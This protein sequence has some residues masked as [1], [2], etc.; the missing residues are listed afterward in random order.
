MQEVHACTFCVVPLSR[1]YTAWKGAHGSL[2]RC[3]FQ[4]PCQQASCT[5]WRPANVC[6][7]ACVK[8][9]LLFLATTRVASVVGA[10][11]DQACHL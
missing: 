3:P 10:Y 9:L 11:L 7:M 4:E 2:R 8:W 6:E 5:F 1:T